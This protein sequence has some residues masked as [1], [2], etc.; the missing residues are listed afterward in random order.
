MNWSDLIYLLKEDEGPNL[1]FKQSQFLQDKDEIAAQIVSFAN[2]NGVTILVGVRDDKSIEGL[3]I[4]KDKEQLNILNIAHDKCSPIVEVSFDHTSS[5]DREVFVIKVSRRK[6]IP[7]A[8]VN[9]TPS[10]I[11]KRIYYIRSGN[12][13]RLVDDNVLRFMFKHAEDPYV[14]IRSTLCIWYNRSSLDFSTSE[15]LS[16]VYYLLPFLES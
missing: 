3:N 4:D 14:S 15:S 6:D 13:K 1:E 9:R 5:S 10:G 7:H 8:I 11:E 2:R 16:Y 12:S